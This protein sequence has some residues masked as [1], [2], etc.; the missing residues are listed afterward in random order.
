M[1][2]RSVCIGDRGLLYIDLN[3]K[4]IRLG[5]ILSFSESNNDY[6]QFQKINAGLST[7]KIVIPKM[8]NSKY[9]K[10]TFNKLKQ[11][12]F[13]WS[14]IVGGLSCLP[15]NSAVLYYSNVNNSI[16]GHHHQ[17]YCI[18]NFS[19]SCV[20]Y[21]NIL[22]YYHFQLDQCLYQKTETHHC[23]H[24]SCS[25]SWKR[26]ISAPYAVWPCSQFTNHSREQTDKNSMFRTLGM[27]CP[28]HLGR[29]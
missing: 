16:V 18:F 23:F 26:F 28:T 3:Q 7:Y 8:N 25:R 17:T 2:V 14:W 5:N 19:A 12:Y 13:I 20:Q 27:L 9:L 6:I 24:R 22:F 11:W 21:I 29:R 1:G 4:S 10:Q 15:R